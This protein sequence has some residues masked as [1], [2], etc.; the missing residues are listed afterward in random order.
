MIVQFV[1]SVKNRTVRRSV[2]KVADNLTQTVRAAKL[3]ENRR[4]NVA[5]GARNQNV[6][7]VV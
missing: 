5:K 2:A 7:S 3:A 1:E 4:V 6:E